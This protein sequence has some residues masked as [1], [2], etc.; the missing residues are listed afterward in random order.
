MTNVELISV[1]YDRTF[2]KTLEQKCYDNNL[3]QLHECEYIEHII[4]SL[5]LFKRFGY[6]INDTNKVHFNLEFLNKAYD[7]IIIVHKFCLNMEKRNEI[8]RYVSGIIG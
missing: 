3:L 6:I 8:K 1:N 2:V 5:R 4:N 7:H